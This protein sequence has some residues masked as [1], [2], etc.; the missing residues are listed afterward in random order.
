[1]TSFTAETKSVCMCVWAHDF[2]GN[3]IRCWISSVTVESIN[4]SA[5]SQNFFFLFLPVPLSISNRNHISSFP[6]TVLAPVRCRL[7][8]KSVERHQRRCASFHLGPPMKDGSWHEGIA[9]LTLRA[10][11]A[12]ARFLGEAWC[13]NWA[14]SIT[15]MLHILQYFWSASGKA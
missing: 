10:D 2:P 11:V 15:E 14:Q 3:I 5:L 8:P 9:L 6:C 7:V 4:N 13:K 1:M 12:T